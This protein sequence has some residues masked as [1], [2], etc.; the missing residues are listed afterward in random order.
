MAPPTLVSMPPRFHPRQYTEEPRAFGKAAT[1]EW[2]RAPPGEEARHTAAQM[3]HLWAVEIARAATV[4]FGSLKNYAEA[5]GVSYDRLTR[6]IRGEEIM[7]LE[8]IAT[9][10]VHLSVQVPGRLLR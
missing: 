10:H 2:K 6:V 3:Q 1:I 9:A 4:R 7:R 5:A 8:D